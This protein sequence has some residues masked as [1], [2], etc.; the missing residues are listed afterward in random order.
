MNRNTLVSMMVGA[1]IASAGAMAPQQAQADWGNLDVKGMMRTEIAFSLDGDGN[2]NNTRRCHNNAGSNAA[3]NAFTGVGAA[4]FPCIDG[5]SSAG[6]T[7]NLFAARLELDFTWRKNDN[8]SGFAKVRGFADLTTLIDQGYNDDN[9]DLFAGASFDGDGALL[10]QSGKYHVVDLAVGYIDYANGPIWL[11]FGKQQVAWGESFGFRT[12]DM[13]NSL[14]LRRHLVFDVQAE[15]F[16][17]ERIATLGVRG[18]YS[19]PEWGGWEVEGFVTTFTPT[20]LAPKGSPY[21]NIGVG[22]NLKDSDDIDNARQRLVYGGRV[23]GPLFNT[24]IEVQANFVSRP[25]QLGVFEFT[26]GTLQGEGAF[27]GVGLVHRDVSSI[28]VDGT[29]NIPVGHAA[30]GVYDDVNGAAAGGVAGRPA[31]EAVATFGA[32]VRNGTPF[33]APSYNAATDPT[34]FDAIGVGNFGPSLVNIMIARGDIAGGAAGV[35][36]GINAL[37]GGAPGVVGGVAYRDAARTLASAGTLMQF[38]SEVEKYSRDW[39]QYRAELGP[40]PFSG[41]GDGAFYRLVGGDSNP[42]LVGRGFL[43]NTLLP[44]VLGERGIYNLAPAV[45]GTDGLRNES[46]FARGLAFGQASGEGIKTVLNTEWDVPDYA[47][48]SAL[49]HQQVVDGAAPSFSHNPN[50]QANWGAAVAGNKGYNLTNAA[51]QHINSDGTGVSCD[52]LLSAYGSIPGFGL[53]G[54]DAFLTLIESA[55][56]VTRKFPRINIVGTGFNYMFQV[57]PDNPFNYVFDGLL[58]KGEASWA[59]NKEFTN[60]LSRFH[61]KKDEQNW[62]FL[63]EKFHKFTYDLP[64]MYMVLQF[65]HRSESNGFDQYSSGIG[66]NGY[67]LVAMG[68]Q[69][70]YL[71]N[72]LRFDFAGAYDF[73]GNGGGWFIQPGVRYKPYEQMQFDLYWNH[74]EGND[75][76]AFGAIDR[77]DEVFTRISRFF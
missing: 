28:N 38:D 40:V 77:H 29:S 10:E 62:S 3:A 32:P 21:S 74:F 53:S 18:S 52:Q 30:S 7:M 48:C 72:K 39:E 60:N 49:S 37:A 61:H 47:N 11:R 20:L 64:A 13:V 70:Q 55:G 27:R 24:G 15:E 66:D 31:N 57:P 41:A 26:E 19:P 5:K 51:N 42:G 14:D 1:G 46:E 8:W 71:Q 56:D 76:N 54:I 17:D 68:L 6:S 44:Y 2:P 63:L 59:F 9:A 75:D 22:T 16:A 43:S 50:L 36:A 12:L 34:T 4:G 25:Q 45:T 23:R 58:F 69:Q 35:N 33:V 65:N 73:A 67:N